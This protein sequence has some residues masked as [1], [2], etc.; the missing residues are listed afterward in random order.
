M[1]TNLV[2]VLQHAIVQGPE[3]IRG[4][5]DREP[6]TDFQRQNATASLSLIAPDSID[7]YHQLSYRG[8]PQARG[9]FSLGSGDQT[10]FYDLVITDPW[11][12]R[13]ALQQDRHTLRQADGKFLITISLG[14]PFGMIPFCYKLIAAIILLPPSIAA[15]F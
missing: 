12:K 9:Y 11:W 3:L 7:L 1:T 4:F 2:P 13:V 5:S 8:N 10:T 6:Y 15:A 14:E